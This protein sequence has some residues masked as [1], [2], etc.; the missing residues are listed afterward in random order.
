[1]CS[2]HWVSAASA[3][4]CTALSRLRR[5][6]TR[7]WSGCSRV[8]CSFMFLVRSSFCL[9]RL[10]CALLTRIRLIRAIYPHA[11][12]AAQGHERDGVAEYRLIALSV[13]QPVTSVDKTS[14]ILRRTLSNIA[15][16][17]TS[18]RSKIRMFFYFPI[19]KRFLT[20]HLFSCSLHKRTTSTPWHSQPC[21]TGTVHRGSPVPRL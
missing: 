1:M 16:R 2:T 11:G 18:S 14:V 17:H 13:R 12:A 6:G 20:E 4:S 10:C 21:S 9:S 15:L 19:S 7:R 3:G 5:P 8:F